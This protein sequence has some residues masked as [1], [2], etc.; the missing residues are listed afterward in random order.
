MKKL[1]KLIKFLN[2]NKIQYYI[3]FID[4]DINVNIYN[5]ENDFENIIKIEDNYLYNI[6]IND[7]FVDFDF[8]S[9]K[10]IIKNLNK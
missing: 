10:K 8:K 3:E 6:I 9:I 1:K 5:V 7:E 4:R 2:K